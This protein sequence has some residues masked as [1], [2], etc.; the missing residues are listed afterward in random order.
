MKI[1]CNEL[2]FSFA[3]SSGPGGQNVNKLNTKVSLRWHLRDSSVVNSGVITRFERKYTNQISHEG[4]VVIS[5]DIYRSQGRNK[6]A[7]I[8][9]INEML[10]SVWHPPK[11]RR[12]TRPKRS[13]I[14]KR[15]K[16][17]KQKSDIKQSR[18]PV[19]F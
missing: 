4:F 11:P 6:E 7:C 12:K 18:K 19:K 1:P 13:A 5:S 10:S 15:L 17:K 2:T 16:Q 9:K 3:R 14:E 8:K